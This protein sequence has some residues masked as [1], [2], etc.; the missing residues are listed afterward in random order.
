MTDYLMALNHE[1][2]NMEPINAENVD[3]ND[4]I[5]YLY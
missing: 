3:G 5:Q 4:K 1:M 2:V